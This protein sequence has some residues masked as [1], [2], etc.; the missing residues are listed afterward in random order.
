MERRHPSRWPLVASLVLGG[1]TL[2]ALMAPRRLPA[3]D[4]AQHA[5]LVQLIASPDE[6]HDLGLELS[7]ASPYWLFYAVALP[8]RGVLGAY[9][10]A[11][12]SFALAA[13]LLVVGTGL[14][15]RRLGRPATLG[16]TALLAVFGC[17]FSFGLVGL[18][19]G[20]ATLVLSL[21]ALEHHLERPCRATSAALAAMVLVGYEAHA[22][23]WALFLGF[24]AASVVLGPARLPSLLLP[25]TAT[26][27]TTAVALVYASS[28]RQ[29]PYLDWLAH[30]FTEVPHA[31]RAWDLLTEGAWWGDAGRAAWASLPLK[32]V[33][34]AWATLGA[35]AALRRPGPG[36]SLRARLFARRHALLGAGCALAAVLMTSQYFLYLRF[37]PL[38]WLFLALAAPP[39]RGRAARALTWALPLAGLPLLQRTALE[40]VARVQGFTRRDI[41]PSRMTP[42]RLA[43]VV[44]DAGARVDGVRPTS[45]GW[46]LVLLAT[47]P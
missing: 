38:A 23:T 42:A 43:G 21:L 31:Q 32:A 40:A 8:F 29:T 37:I 19:W 4:L 35:V 1:S 33:L 41:H 9:G 46:A 27:G 12:L 7:P 14:L 36:P 20:Y 10:A 15:A 26:A 44:R 18:A 3:V 30:D 5:R 39:P 47:A 22:F 28:I 45:L 17:T 11:Q 13:A 24:A 25:L 6:R 34:V 2:L 16:A